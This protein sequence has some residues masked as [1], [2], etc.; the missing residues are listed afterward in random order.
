M[1][2][3]FLRYFEKNYLKIQNVTLSPPHYRRVFVFDCLLSFGRW[4]RIERRRERV[5]E[6]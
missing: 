6:Q 3:M 5:R 4:Y 1:Q 2:I